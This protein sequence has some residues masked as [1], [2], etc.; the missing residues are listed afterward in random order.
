MSGS[1]VPTLASAH[2]RPDSAVFRGRPLG[3]AAR[4]SE[5]R[6]ERV[7]LTDTRD[8]A[9]KERRVLASLIVVLIGFGGEHWGWRAPTEATMADVKSNHDSFIALNVKAVAS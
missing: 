9:R 2:F 4:Q 5:G 8:V 1:P 6:I 7:V 3:T